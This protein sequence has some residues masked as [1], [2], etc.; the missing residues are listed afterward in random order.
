[1]KHYRVNRLVIKP[2]LKCTANC[3]GCASRR[4]LH[5]SLSREEQLSLG[6]W[7]TVLEDA[8]KLGLKNLHISGGEPTLYPELIGLI[9]LGKKLGLRVRMNSNGSMINGEKAE[10]LLKGRS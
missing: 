3:V 4:D 8:S 2:T 7:Q 6:Q 9:E 10:D 5:H 1:M